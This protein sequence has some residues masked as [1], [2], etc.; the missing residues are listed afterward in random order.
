VSFNQEQITTCSHLLVFCADS[1]LMGSINRIKQMMLDSGAKEEDIKAYIDMMTSY[2]SSLDENGKNS[3]ARDQ[4][5]IALGNALN[6]AKALG[7]DS[8][9]MGGFDPMKY[10]EMLNLSDNLM[11]AVICPIGYAADEP[12]PKMRFDNIVL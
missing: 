3:Y 1:D 6:G 9:P 10:K 11:P 5:F 2:V 8:C 12:R 4:V 7:F